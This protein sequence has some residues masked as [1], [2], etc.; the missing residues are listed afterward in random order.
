MFG[1]ILPVVGSLVTR[2]FGLLADSQRTVTTQPDDGAVRVKTRVFT[3][4]K[5]TL[6][7]TSTETIKAY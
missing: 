4:K 6:G 1:N 2:L 7:F 3:C 5:E